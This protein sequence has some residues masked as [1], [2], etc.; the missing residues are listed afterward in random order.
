MKKSRSPK[1][2]LD[3]K[4]IAKA[5]NRDEIADVLHK[6]DQCGPCLTGQSECFFDSYDDM[7]D[8]VIVH[9]LRKFDEK[10]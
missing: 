7:A 8:A 2:W 4:L 1:H 9:L 10:V 3:D 6:A 5:L